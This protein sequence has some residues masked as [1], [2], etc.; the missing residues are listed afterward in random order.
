VDSRVY[1]TAHARAAEEYE[2]SGY[3]VPKIVFWGIN[4]RAGNNPVKFDTHGT[5]M[6]SGFSPSLFK[7][8]ISGDQDGFTPRGVMMQALSDPRYDV[9][10]VT[11]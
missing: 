8:M 2:K 7:S 11:V 5:A 9:P 3:S 4:N 10:G 1:Q 6:V